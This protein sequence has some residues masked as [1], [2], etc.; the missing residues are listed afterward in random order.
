MPL[1]IFKCFL[2]E[3]GRDLIDEW[4][5]SLPIKTRAKF[6][7][8]IE[9]LRDNPHTSWGGY[10][11]PLTGHEGIFEIKFMHN[12]VVYRPLGCFGTNRHEFI[13]LIGARE[14]GDDFE[15]RNAPVTADSRRTIV[16]ENE[17]RAHECDF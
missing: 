9:H 7:T 17:G 11:S 8:I 16:L 10:I 15:P 3:T 1:W 2:S 4:Y 5:N 14:H 13:L 12:R 6:D